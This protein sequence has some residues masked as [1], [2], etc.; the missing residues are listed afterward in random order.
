MSG[1]TGWGGFSQIDEPIKDQWPY[2]AVSAVILS[3]N[4][5]RS[6]PQID[7]KKIGITGISWGGYL[8]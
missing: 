6:L 1:P 5:L 4:F 2:H 8:S 3:H 7:K